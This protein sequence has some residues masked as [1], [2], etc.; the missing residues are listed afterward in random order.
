MERGIEPGHGM[1]EIAEQGLVFALPESLRA[2]PTTDVES[3]AVLKRR[4]NVRDPLQA[5]ELVRAERWRERSSKRI[6]CWIGGTLRDDVVDARGDRIV[7]AQHRGDRA[8]LAHL[9]VETVSGDASVIELW[10]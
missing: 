4:R 5:L 6:P 3:E 1:A 8:P 9:G 2:R 10:K 7:V